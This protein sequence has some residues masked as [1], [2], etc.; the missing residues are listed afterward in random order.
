[1]KHTAALLSLILCACAAPREPVSVHNALSAEQRAAGWQLLFDG[2]STSAWRNFRSDGEVRGWEARA[3]NLVC[4]G[5]GGDLIT[6]DTYADFMLDVEWKIGP[7]GNSGIFF[8]VTEDHGA[9]W[10]TGPEVQVLDNQA[11]GLD[12]LALTAAGSN[13]ALHA[14]SAAVVAP[15]GQFNRVRLIV[16]GGRVVHYLNGHKVVDYTL[17]TEDWREL[18]E[19]SKFGSMPAYG[20]AGRGHIALQDHGDEVCYRNLRIRR[21]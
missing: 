14:P 2:E 10:E 1:M 20:R 17:Q 8:H 6:K 9:V 11:H 13:Y 7:G 15:V 5:G 21:L 4:T 3:G 16:V 19:A 18:V 12:P